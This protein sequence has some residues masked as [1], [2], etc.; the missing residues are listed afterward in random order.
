MTQSSALNTQVEKTLERLRS[1][2]VVLREEHYRLNLD[3]FCRPT[4]MLLVARRRAFCKDFFVRAKLVALKLKPKEDRARVMCEKRVKRQ[5]FEFL[6]ILVRDKRR[7]V[8]G[9]FQEFVRERETLAMEMREFNLKRKS[10][11][12]WA[13]F[14][15]IVVQVKSKDR[16]RIEKGDVI[17]VKVDKFKKAIQEAK[18]ASLIKQLE[19]ERDIRKKQ[20]EAYHREEQMKILADRRK[21][22]EQELGLYQPITEENESTHTDKAEQKDPAL[23]L[24]DD[25]HHDLLASNEDIRPSNTLRRQFL[26]K[27]FL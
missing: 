12:G 14:V 13:E 19:E 23:P 1:Q 9:E 21:L 6:R 18:E 4:E 2:Q 22:L 10:M 7:Q 26:M 17:G 8:L 20:L 15:K 25:Q 11:D 3:R 27:R 16:S 5:L 24:S